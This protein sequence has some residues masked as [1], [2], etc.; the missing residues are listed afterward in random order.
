[1]AQESILLVDDSAAVAFILGHIGRRAGWDIVSRR[2]AEEAGSYLRQHRPDLVV[3]DVNLPGCNGF[4][5]CRSLRSEA[6]F[7]DLPIAMFSQ[8]QRSED[9][10]RALDVGADCVVSKDL[11]AR[12]NDCRQRLADILAWVSTR[13]LPVP[14]RCEGD[15]ISVRSMVDAFNGVMQETVVGP[16]GADLSRR[17][18]ERSAADW[19]TPDGR[20]LDISRLENQVS[21]E[22]VMTFIAAF[23]EQC[24]RVLGSSACEPIWRSLGAELPASASCPVS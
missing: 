24:W 14:I 1:M 13:A 20:G 17:L 9:I 4:D 15:L 8:W 11:L 10:L 18:L 2:D 6:A 5:F 23:A 22:A 19:L 3:L 16:L 12:P 7:G 21:P